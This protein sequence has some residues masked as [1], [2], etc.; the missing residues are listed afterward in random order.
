METGIS[1]IAC[2]TNCPKPHL[3]PL[4]MKIG[5]I[6]ILLFI[7]F[8]SSSCAKNLLVNYQSEPGNTTSLVLRFNKVLHHTKVSVNEKL[9]VDGKLTRSVTLRNLPSGSYNIKC[10]A[11]S[12]WQKDDVCTTLKADINGAEITVVKSVDMPVKNGWYWLGFTS[13]IVWPMVL[14]AGFTL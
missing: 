4:L 14:V 5:L 7:A 9:L 12:G 3:L 11:Y 2:K 6:L 8:F 10:S 1:F 13:L